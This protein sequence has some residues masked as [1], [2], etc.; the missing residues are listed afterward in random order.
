MNSKPED[1]VIKV[2]FE[3][4]KNGQYFYIEKKLRKSSVIFLTGVL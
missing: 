2:K 1:N 3:T 4:P